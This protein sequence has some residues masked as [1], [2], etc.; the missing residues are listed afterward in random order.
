MG[1]IKSYYGGGELVEFETRYLPEIEKVI[2]C[3]VRIA[4]LAE[5]GERV[6]TLSPHEVK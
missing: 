5:R 2:C 3:D 4:V 1:Y 6:F